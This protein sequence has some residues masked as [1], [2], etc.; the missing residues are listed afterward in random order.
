MSGRLLPSA[1]NNLCTHFYELV[2]FAE[3]TAQYGCG[4]V[5]ANMSMKVVEILESGG[6]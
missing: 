6:K 2:H 5:F 4:A 1:K 3:Q